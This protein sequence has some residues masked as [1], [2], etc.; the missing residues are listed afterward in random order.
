MA[1]G[2]LLCCVV[3]LLYVVLREKFLIERETRRFVLDDEKKKRV[4]AFTADVATLRIKRALLVG[5][6][7][8]IGS[9]VAE[10]LLERGV[11]VTVIGRRVP[12]HL[13]GVTFVQQADLSLTGVAKQTAEKLNAKGKPFDFILM[14]VSVYKNIKYN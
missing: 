11:D 13:N 2:F 4:A 3:I 14:T 12:T 7:S 10:Q 6:T 5:G 8:G 9:A 1:I